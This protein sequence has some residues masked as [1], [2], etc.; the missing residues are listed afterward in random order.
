MEWSREKTMKLIEL[1][2][3]NANLWNPSLCQT[4]RDK[5]KRRNELRKIAES[6]DMYVADVTRKIQHLR[7][8]Y[9]REWIRQIRANIDSPDDP[10][11]SSWYAFEYLH[12]LKD[13]SKPYVVLD[14]VSIPQVLLLITLPPCQ[15][16]SRSLQLFSRERIKRDAVSDDIYVKH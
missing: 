11:V 14:T 10:Y 8:Q 3:G 12:F 7:T 4:R 1:L 16:S 9:N 15:I 5:Q 13:S 2:Q 6:L